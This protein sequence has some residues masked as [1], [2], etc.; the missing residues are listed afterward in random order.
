MIT[1]KLKDAA[2]ISPFN[3]KI[4][5]LLRAKRK[6]M[7]QLAAALDYEYSVVRRQLNSQD[8]F[9]YPDLI[10]ICS[11]LQQLPTDFF[12]DR[13]LESNSAL[14]RKLEINSDVTAIRVR[15]T[16]KMVVNFFFAHASFN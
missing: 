4:K 1:R 2:H 12:C 16:Q 11:F 5:H 14:R 6:T 15:E 7:K 3:K 8:T 13:Q 10:K 9:S